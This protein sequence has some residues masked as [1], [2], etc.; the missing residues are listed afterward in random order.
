MESS[1]MPNLTRTQRDI[2]LD[3]KLFGQVVN[4][5]GGIQKYRIALDLDRFRVARALTLGANDAYALRFIEQ[6]DQCVPFID[7]SSPA[8]LGFVDLSSHGEPTFA[9]RDWTEG[10]MSV[11]FGDLADSVFED[12]LLKLGAEEYWY[13]AKAHH[14][15][16][17]GWAFALQMRQF[18]ELY[19][20]C[21]RASLPVKRG[22]FFAHMAS[23]DDERFAARHTRAEA[24]WRERYAHDGNWLRFERREGA[25]TS[26]ARSG[27]ASKAISDTLLKEIS[28]I[29]AAGGVSLAAMF[30]ATIYTYFSRVYQ[31]DDVVIGLPSHNRRGAEQKGTIGSFVN[32]LPCRVSGNGDRP[33]IEFARSV[34]TTMMS[35]QRYGEL[36]IGDL[37]RSL[38]EVGRDHTLIAYPLGFNMQRLNF[39]LKVESV[40]V[41][42]RYLTHGH[43]RTPATIVLCDYGSGGEHDLHLDFN[44]DFFE[45]QEANAIL[46]RIV[47]MLEEVVQS[48]SQ[49]LSRFKVVTDRDVM[50]QLEAA[51]GFMPATSTAACID[52]MLSEQAV[53]TPDAVAV[54]C[55]TDAMTYGELD[56]ASDLV[57]HR[58]LSMGVSRGQLVGICLRRSIPMLAAMLGVLKAGACYVP[59]DPAYPIERLDAIY[60]QAEMSIV[61]TSGDEQHWKAG[62]G[63]CVNVAMLLSNA[64]TVGRVSIDLPGRSPSDLAYTIFTSGTTG[65]PKGVMIEHRNASA[66]LA[67]ARRIY[68]RDDLRS[69]LASTSI[70]FDVSVF[71][72]FAPLVTGGTVVLVDS[73][74]ALSN[75]L[76]QAVSLIS[77][78]PSA[79][80]PLLDTCGIPESVRCINLAGEPLS[81][82]LVER[83]SR[84][85]GA[86]LR[87]LYGPTEDTTYSTWTRRLPGGNESIGRPLDETTAYIL[88]QQ[89][90]L[91]PAGAIG[92]LCLAGAGLARGY[93]GRPDLTD[94]KFVF[95][96]HANARVYRTGDLAR[97]T[98]DQTLAYAG[99]L[100][101]QLKIRGH[102]IEAS[103][104]E[105]VILRQRGVQACVVVAERNLDTPPEL[106]AYVQCSKGDGAMASAADRHAGM[107]QDIAAAIG[108]AL[109]A[110]M[111]PARYGFLESMP[112][113]PNGK[114][115]RG[116]LAFIAIFAARA[117]GFR[118]A[119]SETE[120]RI[121]AIWAEILSVN[122]PSAEV[123]FLAFGGDSLSFLRLHARMQDDFEVRV[124]ISDLFQAVTIEAQAALIDELTEMSAVLSVVSA[125]QIDADADFIEF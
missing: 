32:V 120:R 15:I 12:A 60:A 81:Q 63:S 121:A 25:K 56:E 53:A 70:C 75:P 57:A 124:D 109:P 114:I 14:L 64:S 86:V 18:A 125:S 96:R 97:W 83:I 33:F 27:R 104:V 2:F 62:T 48:P 113:L 98:I 67:W 95:N 22:S 82:S 50:W 111:A 7:H 47:S 24:Y 13:F 119:S 10:R 42:T 105:A 30:V 5:I 92:E 71:E 6:D 116:R 79:L 44:R 77:T 23:A 123:S 122:E 58:L 45:Q 4:N 49:H 91:L 51:T 106:V 76:P 78:V 85:S 89:G 54:V 9:A 99:R 38:R 74:L 90:E 65:Q 115:D 93:L 29:G 26:P 87:D 117:H 28:L 41:E 40:P 61:L 52:A 31:C 72:L 8:P 107:A 112:R 55:G 59:M 100:D 110:Y 102:R 108:K 101:N 73:I 1:R 3:G 88:D 43:E 80:P 39:D 20:S 21:S 66:L 35:D 16:M 94:E 17:D 36:S 34:S 19:E 46:D 118:R 103:E 11:P 69:V 37:A 68:S 84:N